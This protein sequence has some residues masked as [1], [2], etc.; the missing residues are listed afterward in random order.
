[1]IDLLQV[2][3]IPATPK[4][5]KQG[6][7]ST[8]EGE[9]DQLKATMD[10]QSTLTDSKHPSLRRA[11]LHFLALLIRASTAGV[12]D[13]GYQGQTFSASQAKRAKTTL[14][15]VA[16]TDKDNVVRVMAREAIEAMARLNEAIIGM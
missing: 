7:E 14:A 4:P 12:Y 10:S 8:N 9:E 3:S 16:S 5:H 11:A 13:S 1:M 2:E 15:Y 6:S